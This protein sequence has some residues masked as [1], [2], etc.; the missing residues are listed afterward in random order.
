MMQIVISII[1]RPMPDLIY[2][3]VIEIILF[4]KLI[5]INA[6]K[7]VFAQSLASYVLRI[8]IF[9]TRFW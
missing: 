2:R 4:L 1:C 8:K 6:I 5:D 7:R 9:K 3:N